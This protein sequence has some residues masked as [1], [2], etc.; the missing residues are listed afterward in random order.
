M[1]RIEVHNYTNNHMWCICDMLEISTNEN[2]HFLWKLVK[3]CWLL[4]LWNDL[5][6]YCIAV[7]CFPFRF[8]FHSFICRFHLFF[9]YV[10]YFVVIVAVVAGVVVVPF[11][12]IC[13]QGRMKIEIA[14]HRM[15]NE[16]VTIAHLQQILELCLLIKVATKNNRLH[17]FSQR[18][19]C[20]M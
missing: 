4:Y 15:A 7:V 12:E 20:S 6:Y 1:N 14:A 5:C 16:F 3:L 13:V 2:L 9:F 19:N 10:I 18:N 8:H 17:S 11:Y